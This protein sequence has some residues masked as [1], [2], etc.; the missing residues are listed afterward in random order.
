MV[1]KALG[2]ISKIV[3]DKPAVAEAGDGTIQVVDKDN[4]MCFTIGPG[5]LQ[6]LMNGLAGR[7]KLGRF[8]RG[9]PEPDVE[10]CFNVDLLRKALS[11]L[12]AKTT[13]RI[14]VAPLAMGTSGLLYIRGSTQPEFGG[15]TI[16]VVLSGVI[17]EPELDGS[18]PSDKLVLT[19]NEV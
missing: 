11:A 12:P 15:E 7:I 5:S 4:V 3:G 2:A 18:R 13:V 8:I 17:E 9:T 19:I 14:G 10:M 6:A 16:N 1:I